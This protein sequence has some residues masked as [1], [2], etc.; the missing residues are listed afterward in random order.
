MVEREERDQDRR[1]R[2]GDQALPRLP[3]RQDGRHLVPPDQ[4][5]R[6]I[7]ERVRGEDREEH[8]ED[9]KP[10][11]VGDAAQQEDGREAEADP[12]RAERRRRHRHGE[13]LPRLGDPLQQER[14]HDR[15]QE[16]ADHPDRAAELCTEQEQQHPRVPREDQRPQRP[17]HPVELVQGDQAGRGRERPEPPAAEP[18]E[19]QHR[20]QPDGRDQDPAPERIHRPP[21]RRRRCA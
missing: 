3:R 14:E 10:S 11:V 7:G 17:R 16:A 12:R 4:H 5:P 18:N 21:K 19:A 6:E 13:G 20:G 2:R 1:D 15:R 9:R 8:G